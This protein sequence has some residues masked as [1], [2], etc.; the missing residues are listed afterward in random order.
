MP[1]VCPIRTWYNFCNPYDLC[2]TRISSTHSSHSDSMRY[3]QPPS[4]LSFPASNE[5]F[6]IKFAQFYT[7]LIKNLLRILKILKI[8][9][10]FSQ[11]DSNFFWNFSKCDAIWE[12]GSKWKNIHFMAQ[13]RFWHVSLSIPEN[14]TQ[15]YSKHTSLQHF[16]VDISGNY[17]KWKFLFFLSFLKILFS[18][19]WPNFLDRVT[20]I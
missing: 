3:P 4:N 19:L 1:N 11:K 9:I 20:N 18:D 6:Y 7:G 14:H 10:K 5:K 2:E 12:T 17:Q 15:K 16:E 13:W 8:E